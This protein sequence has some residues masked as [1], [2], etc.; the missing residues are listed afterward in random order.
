M[1]FAG[2]TL[3]QMLWYFLIYSFSGWVIEVIYHAVTKGQIINRGFLNG[4]VCP[5]Y[6]SGMLAVIAGSHLAAEK[7]YITVTPSEMNAHSLIL[8]FLGSMLFAT[9]VELLAGWLL[10]VNF[11]MRWW[12]YSKN[13]YNFHGYICLRFS[14]IWGLS[15]T[16]AILLVHPMM[17]KSASLRIP[18]RIGWP[19][20]AVLYM[21]A[22]ADF[23]VTTA[24]INGL[25]RKLRELDQIQ[26]NMRVVSDRLSQTIG[27]GTIKASQK[28]G[29]GQV[30]AALAKA[31]LRDAV[32]EVRDAVA[33]V[34]GTAAAELKNA[35]AS[36]IQKA[37]ARNSRI[38]AEWDFRLQELKEQGKKL[39]TPGRILRKDPEVQHSQYRELLDT[40]KKRIL[41]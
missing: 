22:T 26:K 25:N 27:E 6:G 34:R 23:C 7:G 36:G 9:L 31:E 14:I 13:P 2:M 12:D 29:E 39:F 8:L 10:D 28:I 38:K 33:G 4:P 5:V 1:T 37:T 30:Q 16:G 40:L 20:L 32:A 18:E 41:E 24:M 21:V 11:H 19:V 3:Y 15:I 35:A 17:E